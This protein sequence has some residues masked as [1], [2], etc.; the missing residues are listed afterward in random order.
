MTVYHNQFAQKIFEI[1]SPVLGESMAKGTIKVHCS[2]LG[3]TEESISQKDLTLLSD[4]IRKGLVLFVGT[5]GSM[6]IAS[7][8]M[9]L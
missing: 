9:K 5:E 7:K 4:N 6:L 2:K 3:I 1:I 8:I